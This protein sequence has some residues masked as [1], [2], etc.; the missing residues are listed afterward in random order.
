M[1]KLG[2]EKR[3]PWQCLI[4]V[5]CCYCVWP[6][7]FRHGLMTSL[8]WL[9]LSPCY[10]PQNPQ[11]PFITIHFNF[12]SFVKPSL[13]SLI[14]QSFFL[15]SYFYAFNVL[16]LMYW[17]IAMLIVNRSGLRASAKCFNCKLCFSANWLKKRNGS[18][19]FKLID[20]LLALWSCCLHKTRWGLY[21]SFLLRKCGNIDSY[22]QE[23]WCYWFPIKLSC[24]C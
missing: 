23:L 4:A 1:P 9:Y 11:W 7:C 14:Y 13:G 15:D 5:G 2:L 12:D 8:F 10:L 24:G 16:M 3:L 22:L 19:S 17:C 21:F 6:T 20:R 18:Q